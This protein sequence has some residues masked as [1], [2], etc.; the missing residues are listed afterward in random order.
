[1]SLADEQSQIK[2]LDNVDVIERK[3]SYRRGQVL[4]NREAAE[5]VKV[6]TK[7]VSAT[8]LILEQPT[9]S[10]NPMDWTDFHALFTASVDKCGVSLVDAEKSCLLLKAMSSEESRRIVKYISFVSNG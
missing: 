2:L 1:M 4:C 3:S 8:K 9:F 5:P 10:G 7:V 6:R